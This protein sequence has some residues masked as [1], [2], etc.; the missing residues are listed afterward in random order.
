MPRYIQPVKVGNKRY[1]A[2]FSTIVM[3]FTSRLYPD[4]KS[5]KKAYPRLRVR[6]KTLKGRRLPNGRIE[7]SMT[8]YRVTPKK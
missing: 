8:V 4:L 2:V 6:R 5:I 3:D 1:Y 7:V